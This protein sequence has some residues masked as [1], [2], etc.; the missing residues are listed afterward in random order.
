MEDEFV[1]RP[2]RLIFEYV[3][4]DCT[5]DSK[6]CIADL[7]LV[8]ATPLQALTIRRAV[9]DNGSPGLEVKLRWGGEGGGDQQF[10]QLA[11]DGARGEMPGRGA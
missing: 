6:T 9:A 11:C 7:C 10:N 4:I 1:R 8:E 3:G 2:R 5:H